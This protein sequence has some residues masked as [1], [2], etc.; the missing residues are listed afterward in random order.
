MAVTNIL[1]LRYA[2]LLA[3]ELCV[4]LLLMKNKYVCIKQEVAVEYFQF[5]LLW[6]GLERQEQLVTV[7]ME[8]W[9]QE[10][11]LYRLSV[12]IWLIRVEGWGGTYFT[13]A[14]RWKTWETH[15][16]AFSCHLQGQQLLVY[17]F[18]A[19]YYVYSC[20]MC[21]VV[22]CVQGW[23]NFYILKVIENHF[24]ASYKKACRDTKSSSFYNLCT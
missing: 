13:S 21:T 15:F 6:P 2:T 19:L 12:V 5:Y 18:N 24:H 4:H 7:R 14:W 11:N 1:C 22:L 9:R 3:I 10:Q 23:C 16:V 8:C 20:T 17:R